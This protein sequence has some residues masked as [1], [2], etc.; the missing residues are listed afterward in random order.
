MVLNQLS[1]GTILL[2]PLRASIRAGGDII[3]DTGETVIGVTT[4]YR[5]LT[6]D[7]ALVPRRSDSVTECGSSHM[8]RLV[9]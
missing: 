1:T 7:V 8:S 4:S 6:L 5:L 9:G 3:R 2:L